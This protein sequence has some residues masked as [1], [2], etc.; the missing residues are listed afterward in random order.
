MPVS[1]GD[2]ILV[3]FPFTDLS[4]T[5]LRPAVVLWADSKGQDVTLCFIS[6]QKVETLAA[7]EFV[8][9]ANDPQFS[10]TGLKIT[11]KVRVT[12]IVTLERRM[13][14]RRLG[15][16]SDQLIEHLDQI[17]RQ[18]FQLDSDSEETAMAD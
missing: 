2:I 5:K 18:A 4:Q 7:N 12:R 10:M 8:I 3:P 11:S 6:S 14:R 1:K 9:A 15:K 17:L 13:L 16:L